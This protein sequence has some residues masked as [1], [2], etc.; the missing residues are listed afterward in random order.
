MLQLFL[1]VLLAFP[2]HLALAPIGRRL[3]TADCSGK[4]GGVVQRA[5]GAQF[6]V[7]AAAVAQLVA[8]VAAVV[9]QPVAVAAAVAVGARAALAATGAARVAAVRR[10]RSASSAPIAWAV[11][12]EVA[13]ASESGT[14]KQSA[15]R[16]ATT[17]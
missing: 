5:A 4:G 8:V 2:G 11:R 14:M 1:R 3:D 12:V 10:A 9:V 13:T 15:A 17:W 16:F 6:V 7:L